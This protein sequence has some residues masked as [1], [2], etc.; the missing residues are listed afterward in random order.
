MEVEAEPLYTI[1]YVLYF[2][3]VGVKARVRLGFGSFLF[4]LFAKSIFCDKITN[5]H[6]CF[7]F[8]YWG[9]A[10]VPMK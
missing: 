6:N 10:V 5:S 2:I 3:E 7:S 8:L 4:D 9:K 1:K